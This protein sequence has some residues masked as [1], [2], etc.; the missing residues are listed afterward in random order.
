LLDAFGRNID[1]LRISVTSDCMLDCIYCSR[2]FDENSLKTENRLSLHTIVDVATAA[3]SLGMRRIKITGGEPLLRSNILMIVSRLRAIQG[4]QD[5]SMTSNGLLLGD[6]AHDLA[7]AGLERVNISLDTLDGN[8][9]R[10]I[11]GVNRF[12]DV[13]N[14]IDCALSAG[15]SPIKI[16]MVLIDETSREEIGAMRQFCLGHGLDLQLIN[17]MNMLASK[18]ESEDHEISQKPPL[19]SECRRMRLTVDGK[20]LPCLF[21]SREFAIDDFP[22]YRSALITAVQS[23]QKEGSCAGN[24]AMSQI[25]G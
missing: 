8:R 10:D 15:L 20:L 14:G 5:L 25:G 23:K 21:G 3:V 12:Q 17:R 18:I 24:R 22:D 6:M 4:V 1:T 11:T 2:D 16:N 13:L 19:C 9:Y 7:A